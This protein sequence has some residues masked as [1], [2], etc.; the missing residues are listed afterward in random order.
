MA[1]WAGR[2]DELY[3]KLRAKYGEPPA[4]GGGALADKMARD[5]ALLHDARA[6][7]DGAAVYSLAGKELDVLFDPTRHGSYAGGTLG[8][9]DGK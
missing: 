9:D 7:Q 6:R 1:K 2:Y 5:R 8:C 4:G 3:G